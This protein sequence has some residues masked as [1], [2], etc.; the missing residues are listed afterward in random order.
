VQ[1]IPGGPKTKPSHFITYGALDTAHTS[2]E[3]SGA[4]WRIIVNY[5]QREVLLLHDNA[6]AHSAGVATTTAAECGN[7]FLPYLP[8]SPDLASS[9]FYLLPHV[10]S[11]YELTFYFMLFYFILLHCICICIEM[12]SAIS[13]LND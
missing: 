2:A 8:Y 10:I 5:W 3:P 1:Y 13:L 4:S 6:S 12:R 7:E 11:S 9:G